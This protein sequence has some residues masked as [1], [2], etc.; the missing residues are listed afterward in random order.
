MI[1][2]FFWRASFASD[3]NVAEAR[4]PVRS[5]QRRIQGGKSFYVNRSRNFSYVTS[6]L[7]TNSLTKNVN[8]SNSISKPVPVTNFVSKPLTFP[9]LAT[10]S[11]TITKPVTVTNPVSSCAL[12]ENGTSVAISRGLSAVFSGVERGKLRNSEKE[13]VQKFVNRLDVKGSAVGGGRFSKGKR[14]EWLFADR[15]YRYGKNLSR[16]VEPCGAFSEVEH[17]CEDVVRD[18]QLAKPN[19]CLLV[20]YPRGTSGLNSHKDDEPAHASDQVIT[21]CHGVE[22]TLV[23]EDNSHHEVAREWLEGGDFYVFRDQK[24]FYHGV[25]GVE[26]TDAG[27]WA[28]TFRVFLSHHPNMSGLFQHQNHCC[29]ILGQFLKRPLLVLLVK[30][31][32]GVVFQ[33]LLANHLCH[34]LMLLVYLLG[35][36]IGMLAVVL[37]SS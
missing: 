2:G 6:Q 1:P 29:L 32:T 16:V 5:H 4:P 26:S 8:N 22:A 35:P 30:M 25:D 3:R 21:L 10:K 37:E 9:K 36:W 28:F 17:L 13:N 23:L 34:Q 15:T 19:A 7:P 11:V 20:Y 18:L 12:P 31:L 27:R 14:Y 33:R 24:S